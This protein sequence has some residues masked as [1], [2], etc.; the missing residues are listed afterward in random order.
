M[1]L[2]IKV[3]PNSG[4][5]EIHTEKEKITAYLKSTPENGKAN[6]ELLKLLLKKYST[7]KIVKGLNSKNKTVLVQ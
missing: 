7:A 5:S 6:R 3:K 4:K 2:K 1:L